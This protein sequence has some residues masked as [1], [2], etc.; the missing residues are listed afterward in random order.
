[1]VSEKVNVKD[2]HRKKKKISKVLIIIIA[3]AAILTIA[4]FLGFFSREPVNQV[5]I[6]HPMKDIIFANTN[7]AGEVNGQ[8]VIQQGIEQFDENY[9]IYLLVSLGT[10][11]LHKSYTGYGT[12]KLELVIDQETWSAEIDNGPRVQKASIDDPDLRITM[13]KQTAVEAL[14]SP[15]IQEQ[16]KSA[17]RNG[18]ISIEQIAGKV[19]LASK[20]YLAMYKELTGEEI[21]PE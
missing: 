17:T 12:S 3:I 8:A 15:N 10:S 5:T 14:L 20:G 4:Y 6:E 13:S 21:S 9:I 16:L 2:K 1:M 19:E 7:E 11:H 18:Q